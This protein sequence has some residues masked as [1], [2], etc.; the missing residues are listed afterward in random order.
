M[1]T[2]FLL[3]LC[4]LGREGR[5]RFAH[6]ALGGVTPEALTAQGGNLWLHSGA[7]SQPWSEANHGETQ[8]CQGKQE[9]ELHLTEEH[10]LFFVFS[11][12]FTATTPAELWVF[13]APGQDSAET[14]IQTRLPREST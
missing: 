12:L 10:V 3:L 1:D 7:I 8:D 5:V 4:A 2:P 9:W 14:S 6:L 13:P 11:F